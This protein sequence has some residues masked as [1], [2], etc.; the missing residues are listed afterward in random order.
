MTAPRPPRGRGA[1]YTE[2][3]KAAAIVAALLLVVVGVA[4]IHRSLQHEPVVNAAPDPRDALT[5]SNTQEWDQTLLPYFGERLERKESVES[6]VYVTQLA[7]PPPPANTSTTTTAELAL[8]HQMTNER[9][10]ETLAAIEIERQS[11]HNFTLGGFSVG[12]TS[13]PRTGALISDAHLTLIPV[14]LSLKE[15]F[16][17][18]RPSLLDPTLTTAI[19]I[20]GHP[21]YPSGHASE[22]HMVAYLL[23]ELDPEN[24][25]AYLADA[26]RIAKNREIAGVHY[27]SDT[28]AGK[29]LAAQFVALYLESEIGR[30]LLS[31]AQSEW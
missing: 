4:T 13:K 24:T 2:P 29:Q 22:A 31:D 19:P 14:I 23:A 30:E 27:P 16:D 15:R 6:E 18:V 26:A 11:I 7:L 9:N 25:D 21:A 17:R 1:C 12:T 3:M 28:E 20:P 10:E 8:L 5:F